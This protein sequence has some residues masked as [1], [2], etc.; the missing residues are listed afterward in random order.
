MIDCKEA[1][2]LTDK[3]S[4]TEISFGKRMSLK[5][6]VMMCKICRRYFKDSEALMKIF[7]RAKIVNPELSSEDKENLKKN[8]KQ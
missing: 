5:F 7:K 1:A 6:H 2:Y 3:Q 8:L 4:I